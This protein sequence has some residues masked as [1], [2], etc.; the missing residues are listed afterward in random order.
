M[1]SSKNYTVYVKKINNNL[2]KNMVFSSYFLLIYAICCECQEKEEIQR[3]ES[4]KREIQIK[5]ERKT[6]ILFSQGI[7]KLR[8]DVSF[9]NSFCQVIIVVGQ[10]AEG[11]GSCLLDCGH[12]VQK[13]RSKKGH[14]SSI[15]KS[16]NVLRPAGQ[17]CHGL[18]KPGSSL[19]ILLKHCKKDG[20]Y[21]CLVIIERIIL[22]LN[23]HVYGIY[24]IST[25][26]MHLKIQFIKTFMQMAQII[27]I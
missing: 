21:S 6:Y 13:E 4:K 18:H 15:L 19:L 27:R 3:N 24:V 17:L 2:I 8:K 1:F 25:I 11:E 20:G 23:S 16:L 12:N 14:N 10:S 9:D 22:F 5:E 26:C 7:N